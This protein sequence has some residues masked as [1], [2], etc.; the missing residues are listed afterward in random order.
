MLCVVCGEVA[1]LAMNFAHHETSS[2]VVLC[3]RCFQE[4]KVGHVSTRMM[5]LREFGVE[6]NDI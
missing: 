4:I 3:K 6:L 1:I 5:C 2:A